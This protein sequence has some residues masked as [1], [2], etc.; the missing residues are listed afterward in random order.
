MSLADIRDNIID[1]CENIN[2]F[3]IDRYK[4]DYYTSREF[5]IQTSID[6]GLISY[7]IAHCYSSGKYCHLFAIAADDSRKYQYSHKQQLLIQRHN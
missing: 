1:N 7:A 3:V 5:P 2:I 6:E 4:R